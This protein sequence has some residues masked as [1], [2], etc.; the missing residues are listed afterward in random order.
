LN[1]VRHEPAKTRDGFLFRACSRDP[2]EPDPKRGAAETRHHVRIGRWTSLF[3]FQRTACDPR[4]A[5]THGT[6]RR[7][8]RKRNLSGAAERCQG[9]GEADWRQQSA[10]FQENKRRLPSRRQGV[11]SNRRRASGYARCSCSRIRADRVSTE[12]PSSSVTT[13]CTTTGP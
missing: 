7:L 11:V 12:S 1:P 8:A 5:G 13:R 9:F 10:C 6:E 4:D 3:S 2:D